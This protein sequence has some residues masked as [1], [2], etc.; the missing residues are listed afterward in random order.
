MTG[1]GRT[2]IQLRLVPTARMS[3]GLE[4]PVFEGIRGVM[5]CLR[6]IAVSS[7]T[8]LSSNA[9]LSLTEKFHQIVML[10]GNWNV[11]VG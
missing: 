5:I 7:T 3:P 4:K 11:F 8:L 2:N 10:H 6:M 9:I 1:K